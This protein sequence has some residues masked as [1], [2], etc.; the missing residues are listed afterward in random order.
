[1]QAFFLTNLKTN[2]SK[3]QKKSTID[4]LKQMNQQEADKVIMV[5]NRQVEIVTNT[6]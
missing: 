5:S 2:P 1:M 3:K 4:I 6:R